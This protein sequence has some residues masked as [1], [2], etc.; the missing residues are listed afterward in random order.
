MDGQRERPRPHDE[1]RG[2][3]P[4]AGTAPARWRRA[5]HWLL[6]DREDIDQEGLLA[7]RTL[8]IARPR[9]KRERTDAPSGPGRDEARR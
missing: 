5:L 9:P 7:E 8:L 1:P 2:F 4:P 6:G 3:L